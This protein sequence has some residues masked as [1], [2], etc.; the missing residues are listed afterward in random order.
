M[1]TINIHLTPHDLTG[2]RFSY[3]PLVTMVNSF[4]L[5]A[6]PRAYY[7]LYHRWIDE[8]QRALHGLEFPFMESM[9]LP[10]SYIADFITPTPENRI[11]DTETE[12]ARVLATPT[13]VI[14]ANV[15]KLIDLHGETEPRRF[16]LSH[17]SEAMACLI[18]EIRLYWQRV[19]AAHWDRMMLR[20]DEDI[21]Q[22]ARQ[23]ALH[24]AD[25][26]LNNMS[27][28]MTYVPMLI[29]L[30]KSKSTCSHSLTDVM[31]EG[32]GLYLV[33]SMLTCPESV[34]WQIVPEF[35]PMLIYGAH[36]SSLW[37]ESPVLANPE[38]ELV[39]ALGEGRARV[40]L[41]LTNPAPTSELARQLHMTSGALSQQLK[42][43]R[44][45]GLV[46]TQRRGYF[47]YYGLSERGQKLIDLFV[48]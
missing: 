35:E 27:S 48:G 36:G 12:L 17:P 47:V 14:R 41:A 42:R 21:L 38:K 2:L 39:M 34:M 19:L 43:L 11:C 24:G 7:G 45:A 23:L 44:G 31:L 4:K 22:H 37:Y 33:P 28:A 20:F 5:L 40:L 30:D 25:V 18:E 13:D 6:N 9:I 46:I 16:F 8:A 32:R 1:N 29:L 26:M 3:S 15:E 10:H